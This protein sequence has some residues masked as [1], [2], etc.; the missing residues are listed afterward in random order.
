M[1]TN[2]KNPKDMT[3]TE[4][5]ITNLLGVR[6]P[7][8]FEVAEKLARKRCSELN[9][10]VKGISSKWF[11]NKSDLQ[12]ILQTES[13]ISKINQVLEEKRAKFGPL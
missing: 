7:L 6:T 5:V 12:M 3:R 8:E 2:Q 13:E 9:K 10:I 11:K 4:Y 1:E